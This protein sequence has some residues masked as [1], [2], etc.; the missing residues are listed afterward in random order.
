MHLSR[1]WCD[2]CEKVQPV[3]LDVVPDDKN[4]HDV[5]DIVC[6]V[7]KSILVT[8][9]STSA[10]DVNDDEPSQDI[11]RVLGMIREAIERTFDMTLPSATTMDGQAKLIVQAIHDAAA[12]RA[13]ARRAICTMTAKDR[14]M[15]Y[16]P[17]EDGTYVIE[18]RIAEGDCWQSQPGAAKRLCSGIF[19]RECLTACVCRTSPC[20]RICGGHY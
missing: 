13:T 5:A 20:D 1:A 9:H 17:K 15:I 16:G 3:I 19:R 4:D 8:L 11:S 2:T 7:C 10:A 18:F 14:I 6:E 12:D